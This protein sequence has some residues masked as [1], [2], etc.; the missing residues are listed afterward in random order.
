MSS[1]VERWADYVQSTAL[2]LGD[3]SVTDRGGAPLT[4]AVGFD[5]WLEI[6]H[7]GHACA[8]GIYLVGNGASA[9]LASHFAA[10][11]CKNGGLRATTF[12]EP[13]LLTATA[14]DVAFADVFALPLSR[15]ARS[16]DLLVAISSSGNSPNI[17]R[18]L[19]TAR[20]MDMAIVTLTARSADNRARQCGDLNF[21]VPA[22]RYGW[23]ECAHQ[24][25]LHYWMDQYLNLYRGGAL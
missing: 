11:A 3:L 12:N 2:A 18:A 13:A 21:Y 8:R 20:S 22:V 10:D 7:R 16:G 4:A 6:T 9:T 14:N 19:E 24:L 23:A 5:Q 1:D 25:L 17:L 15:I